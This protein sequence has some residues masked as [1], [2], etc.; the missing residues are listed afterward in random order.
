MPEDLRVGADQIELH[1]GGQAA[2]AP[3]HHELLRHGGYHAR[4]SLTDDLAA[5]KVKAVAPLHG[6]TV[7]HVNIVRGEQVVGHLPREQDGVQFVPGVVKAVLAVLDGQ[8]RMPGQE[9]GFI[10][11]LKAGH[12]HLQR[13]AQGDAGEKQQYHQ[14]RQQLAHDEGSFH[15]KRGCPNE[16]QPR[17]LVRYGACTACQ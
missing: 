10:L 9:R 5:G 13:V 4:H 14:K 15:E 6:R 1:A 12:V 17:R 7:I 3:V 11:R 16:E 2:D 8:A